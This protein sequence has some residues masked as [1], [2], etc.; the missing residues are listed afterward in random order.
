MFTYRSLIPVDAQKWR[1]I[2]AIGVR[3]FPLGF[4]M[5]PTEVDDL[6]MEKCQTILD[7]GGMRGVFEGDVLV[8]FCGY[9]HFKPIRIRH[10]GDIGPF[11]VME[12]FHGS[13]AAQ[14]LMAGVLK[15]AKEA[16]VEQLELSVAQSNFRA[17]AFYE[18]QG[19]VCYGVHPD[20]V[21]DDEADGS[22]F[23]YRRL[24]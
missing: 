12:N 17:I 23:F 3:K 19:F 5:T 8:G 2:F 7:A 11:F 13:G 6:T 16:G 20:A 24:L 4:L 18:R 15:E 21:R 9:R 22:G 1:E 10:R 14:V